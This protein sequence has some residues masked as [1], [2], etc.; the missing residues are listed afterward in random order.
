GFDVQAHTKT[1]GDLRR[2]PGESDADYAR[3]M[4][5]ELGDPQGLFEK[6]LGHRAELLAY[7]YGYHDEALAAKVQ[8][9][10]YVAAFTVRREGNPAFVDPLRAHRSQIYSEMTLDDFARNLTIFNAEPIR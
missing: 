5:L 9:Y 1:H 10:G 3:R 6:N 8:E 2:R 4:K 7:P